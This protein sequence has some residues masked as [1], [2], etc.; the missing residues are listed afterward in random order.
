MNFKESL[1]QR[2]ARERAEL[3][4]ELDRTREARAKAEVGATTGPTPPKGAGF[5]RKQRELDAV[6]RLEKSDRQKLVALDQKHAAEQSVAPGSDKTQERE[7][8][9]DMTR[10][11]NAAIALALATGKGQE[12]GADKDAAPT[13]EFNKQAQKP[14]PTN[15]FN[16]EAER[17]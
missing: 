6:A 14:G 3:E 10:L 1:S 9:I 15:D 11:Q 7:K 4:Q 17:D 2:Q 12:Q 5:D 13:Q 8:T 16:R